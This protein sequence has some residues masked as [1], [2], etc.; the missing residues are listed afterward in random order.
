MINNTTC[1]M[2]L[3]CMHDMYIYIQHD[4]KQN[5]CTVLV[6]GVQT[7]LEQCGTFDVF[8]LEMLNTT[9]QLDYSVFQNVKNNRPLHNC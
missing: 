2:E 1:R 6:R 9:M 3:R 5:T 8:M 4:W 7:V